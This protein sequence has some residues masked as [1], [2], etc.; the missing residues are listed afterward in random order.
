MCRVM[1]I[2]GIK[3][4]HIEK[5]QNLTKIMAKE[6]SWQEPDGVG[7]AAIT[8]D[9]HIY[10]E[11]WL[12]KSQAFVLHGSR[13]DP[14]VQRIEK[15]FGANAIDFDN[16]TVKADSY[17]IFG[18]VSREN[19]ENTVAI[20]L[21]AR[22]A[23]QGVKN[24]Q[25][26][27]PFV[28][29]RIEDGEPV[30]T[31]LIHNGSI[32]N[33]DKLTKE[34]STC[35]SEV[36]LH[37]YLSNMMYHNPWGVEQLAKTLVGS[38]TVGVL[39]SQLDT[40]A[41]KWVPYLDIFKSSKELVGG[42]VP[43]IETF[44]FTTTKTNLESAVKSAEMTVQ[45]IFTVK[46]GFLHRLNAITGEA[47]IES[48]SFTTSARWMNQYNT[49]HENSKV[50]RISGR[51]HDDIHPYGPYQSGYDDGVTARDADMNKAKQ[52]F[53]RHHPDL[54]TTPYIEAKV[55]EAE[56]DFF[57]TLSKDDKTNHAALKLVSVALGI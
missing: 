31:A 11:K 44:V 56:R 13:P 10:G 33:H 34:F 50:H 36:I 4:Q 48:V 18:H 43:E 55:T 9:C 16:P 22:K 35:D 49:Q 54:F 28:K 15:Q 39:S 17:E 47:E 19:I 7:Y 38:Y 41:N 27:H 8:K 14:I 1:M 46:D 3:K 42:Y 2:A 52:D 32:D 24:L 12:D 51:G 20:I 40:E 6:I 37:E 23:T 26:V 29:K 53:E 57:E 45:N 5:V 21:H 25:N 30:A